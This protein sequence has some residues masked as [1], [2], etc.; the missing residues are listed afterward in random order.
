[1]KTF[2][3]SEFVTLLRLELWNG[4]H[5]SGIG[6]ISPARRA[7]REAGRSGLTGLR[8]A[9][10]IM[11]EEIRRD[12][13][14]SKLIFS[15]YDPYEGRHLFY[16][17]STYS[18]EDIRETFR[19]VMAG[20]EAGTEKQHG[21][22]TSSGSLFREKLRHGSTQYNMRGKRTPSPGSRR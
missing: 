9:G 15:V 16:E 10:G 8:L 17:T 2:G 22:L 19:A 21:R 18:P 14:G 7:D 11:L 5:L 12:G 6:Y 20:G 3:L 1:M 13:T 4:G